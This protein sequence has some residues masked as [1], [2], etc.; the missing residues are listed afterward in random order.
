MNGH[1]PPDGGGVH[2]RERTSTMA[3]T[4]H[5]RLS[6]PLLLGMVLAASPALAQGQGQPGS[7]M[8]GPPMQGHPGGMTQQ[9]M[10]RQNMPQDPAS[11]AYM[12]S[13]RTMNR[14][15]M[16]R[17]M[18][19]DADRDFASMMIAHHQG[20]IDMARVE[21]QHGKDPALKAMAQKVIDDQSKEIKDLQDWLSQHPAQAA[22][23]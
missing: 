13:M 22:R 4:R 23:K 19:G 3:S 8:G 1:P 18:T 21:L 17:R 16:G 6:A 10:K 20:A 11:R 14:S 9:D 12:D 7:P 5:L 15:M 2:K